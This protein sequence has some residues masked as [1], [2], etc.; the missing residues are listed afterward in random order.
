MDSFVVGDAFKR[1]G[2][3]FACNRSMGGW[4]HH[5]AGLKQQPLEEKA[6]AFLVVSCWSILQLHAPLGRGARGSLPAWLQN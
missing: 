4:C 2:R 5:H 6:A 1:L 3:F